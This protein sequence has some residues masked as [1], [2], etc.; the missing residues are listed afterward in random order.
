MLIVDDGDD[1]DED[2]GVDH[3]THHPTL[4][5]APIQPLLHC[6]CDA[7]AA[8][9]THHPRAPRD[10]RQQLA[11]SAVPV[12]LYK[13]TGRWK[14]GWDRMQRNC[15]VVD[16]IVH[17]SLRFGSFVVNPRGSPRQQASHSDPSPYHASPSTS[18]YVSV[19]S[20]Q[21]QPHTHLLRQSRLVVRCCAQAF[22]QQTNP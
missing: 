9:C 15:L 14:I 11:L 18:L 20:E 4:S 2:A 12:Q 8:L 6:M 16:D 7:G 17:L 3:N 19:K 22:C 13:T 1:G 10:C 5:L 21:S